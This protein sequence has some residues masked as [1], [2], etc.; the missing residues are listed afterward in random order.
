MKK[1]FMYKSMRVFIVLAIAVIA[2]VLLFVL[3]PEA[4]H[5][6]KKETGLLVETLSATA[7]NTDM[8]I[9]AYGTV[10]P[11]KTLKLVAEVKGKIFDIHPKF[12]E[13]NFIDKNIVLIKIDPRTYKLEVDRRKVQI[14]QIDA[15]FDKLHQE[16]E[17][18]KASLKIAKSDETLALNDYQRA[19]ELKKNHVIAQTTLDRAEQRYLTSLKLKQE[20][21]NQLALTGPGEKD[22]KARHKMAKVLLRQAK[23]DFEKSSIISPFDG[24]VLEKA[25][26]IGQHVNGGQYLGSI[27]KAGAFDIR[28]R[29]PV[30]DLKWLPPVT[31]SDPKP[32]AKIFF[33]DGDNLVIWHGHVA[34]IFAGMDEKTRTLPVIVETDITP[35]NKKKDALSLR[36]GMFVKVR[37]KGKKIKNIFVLPRHAVHD[38]DMIYI[39]KGN[40]LTIRN[41][42]VLRSFQKS[43]F[44]DGGLTVGELVVT[45]SLAGVSDGMPVRLKK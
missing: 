10:E 16:I 3:R 8:I 23:L 25:V 13:G 12:K 40:H 42:D 31:G 1:G 20:L 44:I 11:R 28:V 5:M 27:Y 36:S 26:E 7:V 33:S 21:E 39:V 45:T 37:I 22:L 9:E 18:L 19:K 2:A 17:N 43:V 30:K 6:E 14:D 41:V 4:E 15:L 38:K 34:R 35:D 29:I 24:W 32:E